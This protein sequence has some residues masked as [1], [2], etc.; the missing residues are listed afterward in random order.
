MGIFKNNSEEIIKEKDKQIEKLQQ[1]NGKLKESYGLSKSKQLK[2]ENDNLQQ[3]ISEKDEIIFELKT[4]LSKNNDDKYRLEQE[5]NRYKSNYN[6]LYKEKERLKIQYDELTK[7]YA[8]TNQ[9]IEQLN[10]SISIK[11]KEIEAYKQAIK[12]V[13]LTFSNSEKEHKI[14]K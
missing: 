7:E 10:Q 1:E 8:K 12:N 3:I 2:E 6:N 14:K 9:V 5:L 4:Q 13:T 11:N